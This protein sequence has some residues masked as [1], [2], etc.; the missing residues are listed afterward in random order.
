M[1]ICGAYLNDYKSGDSTAYL[2]IYFDS[3]YAKNGT[4]EHLL[5]LK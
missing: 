3:M 2:I 5:I 4:Q 1:T